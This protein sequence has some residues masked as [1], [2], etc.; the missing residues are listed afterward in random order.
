MLKEYDKVL[1]VFICKF[2]ETEFPTAVQAI[3]CFDSHIAKR[4]KSIQKFFLGQEVRSEK[5][6]G[7]GIVVLAKLYDW[8]RKVSYEIKIPKSNV[9]GS[10]MY[11]DFDPNCFTEDTYL[12]ED[13]Y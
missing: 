3:K 13:L 6:E 10:G 1:A 4:E 2:C 9:F 12:Q 5:F 8:N 7:T 11:D